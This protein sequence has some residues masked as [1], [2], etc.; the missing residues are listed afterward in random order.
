MRIAV[1]FSAILK[2]MIRQFSSFID[3]PAST[4]PRDHFGPLYYTVILK[5]NSLKYKVKFSKIYKVISMQQ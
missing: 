5:F 3:T 1:S 4:F 2:Q